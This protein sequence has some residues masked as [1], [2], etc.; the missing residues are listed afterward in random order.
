MIFIACI[1][2]GWLLCAMGT[3]GIFFADV[4]GRFPR[5]AQRDYGT[6]LRRA[7]FLGFVGG[8]VGLVASLVMSGF[9]KYGW[10]LK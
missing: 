3:A 2:I 1:V 10:R 5:N 6:D 9:C 8:P 4:Q 7:W